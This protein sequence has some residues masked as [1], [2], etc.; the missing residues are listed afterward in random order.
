MICEIQFPRWR[1]SR[2][3]PPGRHNPVKEKGPF[4][5]MTARQRFVVA[6]LLLLMVCVLGAFVLLVFEKVVPP[7]Y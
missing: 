6:L 4:L 2:R 3:N 5:G 1:K 7:L